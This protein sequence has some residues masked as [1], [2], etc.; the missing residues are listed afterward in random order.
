VAAE[1]DHQMAGSLERPE[2]VEA[3]DA[4]AGSV[5]DVAVNG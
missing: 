3:R 1:S 4:P 2:H 5:R